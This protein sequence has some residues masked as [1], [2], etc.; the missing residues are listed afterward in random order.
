MHILVLLQTGTLPPEW[1]LNIGLRSLLLRNNSLEGGDSRK[2]AAAVVWA[3]CLFLSG[4]IG[5]SQRCLGLHRCGLPRVAA[6]MVPAFAGPL[7]AYNISGTIAVKPGNPGLC[8]EVGAAEPKS[9]PHVLLSAGARIPALPAPTHLQCVHATDHAGEMA[10][11]IVT[12]CI[13]LPAL[14]TFLCPGATHDIL[15]GVR[16]RQ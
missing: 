11:C 8:G 5:C 16:S 14:P 7:P 13:L 3:S 9:H 12:C 2:E 1:Q 10:H 15:Y 4:C 6:L